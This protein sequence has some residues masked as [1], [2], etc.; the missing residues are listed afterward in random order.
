MSKSIRYASILIPALAATVGLA[1]PAGAVE[2]RI[3]VA[4]QAFDLRHVRLLDGPVK[5]SLEANR[6]YLRELDSDRLLYVF[7]VNAKLDAP[8]KPLGGWEKPDC[9]LRGHFVGHYLTA[10]ALM[11]AAAGD[12]VLKA[13]AGAMVAELAKCQQALGGEYLSAFPEG[14]WDRLELPDQK[15]PWAPYYTIHKI[16]A[17]LYDMHALCGNEQ[18]LEVLKGMAAYFRKRIDKLSDVQ[19]DRILT[20]EFGGMSEVLHDLYSVTG[21][22]QHLALAHRFDQASFLGPLALEHDNLSRIH[23]NTQIP[24]ICAA[25]RRHELTGDGR[26]R[27]IVEYFWD[28]IVNTRSYATGGSTEGEFWPEPNKLAKPLTQSNIETCTTYNML[29][30]SRYLIGW[31]GE[32]KY[33]DYYQKAWLNGILG[34]QDPA[35]GMLIYFTPLATGGRKVWGTPDD[36][37]WCCYGTGIESFAKLADSIYFHDEDGL[38]VH[39]FVPSEVNWE[40]TGV[41]VRQETL[42]PE[43]PET[44]LLV[45]VQSPITGKLHVLVPFWAT[46]GVEVKINGQRVEVEAK[47][48]TYL[49]LDQ[50]W[51]DGDKVEIRMPMSLTACPMPDDPELVGLLYGP[52]VLAG[53]TE[54]PDAYFLGDAKHPAAWIEPIEPRAGTSLTFRTTG[55]PEDITFIPLNQ[56]I[57]QAYGV[58]FPTVTKGSPRH[59]VLTAKAEARRKRER[60]MVDRVYPDDDVTE[61]T[62]NLKVGNSK[63]GPHQGRRFRHAE[64]GEGWSWDLKV[65]PDAP[66]VLVCV[67]WGDDVGPRTFDILV[68]DRVIATQSLNK[69]KPGEF[70][71]AEYAVP[72]DLTRGKE[73]ITVRFR[74]HEKN[75]AGGVFECMTR[76]R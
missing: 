43:K 62:H 48:V 32:A 75:I 35:D 37:F 65:L 74:P 13:K 12:E 31:T 69:D 10:C 58:Y 27:T 51:N 64:G 33:A 70:F 8:G 5:A 42:F 25:A 55:Q 36:S 29:K 21:D 61:P 63:A 9:E 60:G 59:R 23:A 76:K 39:L 11:Y 17:G 22:E 46:Q 52:L 20:V 56:V 6:K 41:R 28:R 73:E 44:T 16:M 45:Q 71:D 2:D 7:R 14:F 15:H 38:Y 3:T 66:M 54:D 49:T 40:E 72:E 67:Y 47:P 50:T 19:F 68:G 1:R 34:T 30:V 26:Y 53:L 24:K 18:A 57:K 4:L